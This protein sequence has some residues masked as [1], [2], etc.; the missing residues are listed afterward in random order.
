MK[1]SLNHFLKSVILISLITAHV[2]LLTLQGQAATSIDR[3]V[4]IA[5]DEIITQSEL[6]R[7]IRS[8]KDAG[9]PID[10]KKDHW[11]ILKQLIEEQ[12]IVQEAK[13]KGVTV[14]ED[15]LEFALKDIE[16]RNRIPDRE[17][18][19]KAVAMDHLSWE[20]YLN[21]L[22]NQLTA[23]KLLSREVNTTVTLSDEKVK[24]YYEQ[25]ADLFA[26][27]DRVQLRQI[28]LPF[29]E[30]AN[31]TEI[32]N[33]KS[34]AEKIYDEAHSGTDFL[35]LVQRY[36]EGHEKKEGGDL[37]FFK[38]GDL[39]PKIDEVIFQLKEGE[40][41]PPIETP[42]GIHIFKIETQEIGRLR[43]F[44]TVQRKIKEQLI[45]EKTAE[46]RSQWIEDL[47][48]RSFVEVK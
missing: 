44:E 16:K 46:L 28:L 33:I 4:A 10:P 17:A 22:S 11:E 26:L 15:E 19:K 23:L 35:Q 34:K 20:Q 30:N 13:K 8:R 38:R 14:T 6:D 45:M 39:T 29:S 7:I 41:T 48:K 47:R 21:N 5:G 43:P 24:E 12:L 37:G 40:I 32:D 1:N 9:E 18:L 25:H 27:P 31:Q 2:M 42:L 3:V 36:S